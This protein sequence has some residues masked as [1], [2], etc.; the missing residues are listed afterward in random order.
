MDLPYP[1]EILQK[2]STTHISDA[3]DRL[4]MIGVLDD[5]KLVHNNAGNIFG[6]AFTILLTD[7]YVSN[8]VHLGVEAITTAGEGQIIVIANDKRMKMACWGG[9]L[10]RAAQMNKIN[11]VVIDGA[12]RDVDEIKDIGFPAFTR[13]VA[14]RASRNRVY[15]QDM[16]VPIF[17]GEVNIS[18]D[19][20][21]FADANGVVVIPQTNER[22]ILKNAIK[23]MDIEDEMREQIESGR[24]IKQ[25]DKDHKYNELLR[26]SE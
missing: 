18:P 9:I 25:V 6:R 26:M 5:I 20:L 7:Q 21:I 10:S 24:S 14:V 16:Q 2:L 19:D 11:G 4:G 17:I 13:G 1:K 22:E 12:C 23:L 8:P 15:Q 3:L